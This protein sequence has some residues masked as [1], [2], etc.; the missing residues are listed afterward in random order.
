[1][2]GGAKGV[3]L[4]RGKSPRAFIQ[5]NENDPMATLPMQPEDEMAP[6]M[7][8]P[9]E[10]E[11]DILFCVEI[12]VMRDGTF[13]VA[14]E[15]SAYEGA[16]REGAEQAGMSKPAAETFQSV[17]DAMTAAL[18]IIKNGGEMQDS[19]AE[20]SMMAEGYKGNSL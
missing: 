6:E 18:S 8:E 12:C 16:E 4:P 3:A 14:A 17:K 1:M 2:A 10:A 9:M 7:E 11:S 19:G 5:P 20:K 15:D 13:T